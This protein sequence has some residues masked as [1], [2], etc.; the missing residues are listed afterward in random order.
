MDFSV[1]TVRPGSAP[2]GWVPV[3]ACTLLTSEQPLRMA[4]YDTLFAESL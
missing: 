2:P 4:R 3:G 1:A